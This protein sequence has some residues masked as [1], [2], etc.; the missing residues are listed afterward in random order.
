MRERILE[1]IKKENKKLNPIDIMNKI[2][3]NSS[4]EDLRSLIHELDLMCRDGI[5]RCSS[6][7]TYVLNDLLSGELDVHEKGNAH[8][9]V[10][11]GDD[12]FI[13]RDK[14][15]GAKNKDTVLVEVTNKEKGEGK[16]VKILSR[17]IGNNVAEV[18][19]V[20]GELIVVPLKNEND[21]IIEFENNDL[22]LVEGQY[23]HIEY[24]R[25]LG[26]GKILAR[27]D[28]V[29]GHKN[30]LLNEG[31]E[32]T[33][34][35]GEIAK[36][37]CE[38]GLNLLF[39]NEVLE[40]ASKM[41]KELS[42][43]MI[44]SG[45]ENGRE[46]FRNEIIFTIDGKDTKDIDDAIS[47]KMLPNGNY[48]LG[49][50]IADVSYYVK[51]GSSI[52]K[53]AEKRGNSNYLGNKVL[54]M[55]PVE[56][57]NGI[58]SLNPNVDRFTTSCVMEIDASGKV[59]NRRVVKGIINSK[60]KMNYDAVQDLIDN[61]D[62]EDTKDYT[63]LSYTAIKG[64]T[65]D[66]IA[67]ANCIT[68][69]ELKKYN[70]SINGD[71]IGKEIN[72]PCK[73]VIKNAYILS[74]LIS[75]YKHTRGEII[76]DGDEAKIYQDENDEPYEVSA[77]DQR[78]AERIIEDFMV[79]ANEQVAEFLTECNL[80]TYRIHAQPLTKKMEDYLKYLELCGIHYN[81][82][83]NTEN[84][85][86]RECQQLLEYLREKE[87]SMYKVLNKKLLR[88]MQK[89]EY[90][91]ENIGH[92][93]IASPCY[94][95]FTSPIRR[96]DDLL[97]H[98][99]LGY[100]LE[101]ERMDERFIKSWTAYLNTLCAYISECERNSEKCEY[102]VDDMLKARFME[103]HIGEEFDV[104]V[105]NIM[106]GAFFVQTD[107]YIDGRVDTIIKNEK[108][109][110]IAGYYNYDDKLM[111]YTRNGRVD[112]RSG[113]RVRVKCVNSDYLSREIDFALVR[114]L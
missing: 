41:P 73:N 55:L 98:T 18:M 99:S 108:E 80:A 9:I 78:P 61:K 2:K 32:P 65:L 100:I 48:E 95:H 21:Y 13:P 49:V 14:I 17:S 103:S 59:V 67:F 19:N 92:F 56:L 63:T 20:D 68:V 51:P 42:S 27:V 54:P 83:F 47:I 53:E 90:S 16:V 70:P 72:V 5:L 112:L 38:F 77:R 45:L 28:K 104:T 36:I 1:I 25:D 64:D 11:D 114:K 84:V 111:A 3:K 52:W 91:T 37:A 94:T 82:R 76:F 12:I 62:T 33:T 22:N 24:L 8:L 105:D 6:G 60:K 4:V 35:S 43:E 44:N 79:C 10:K 66:S 26:K 87:E 31:Q 46:D 34:I 109:S 58:C 30:A 23:V 69:D 88:S 101:E 89:A 15:K 110:S 113:D 50:H 74:K 81:G 71:I 57:S 86:S 106:Q 102:A 40:E 29:L 85:S 93:G 107:N 96:M 7:N 39:P 97:N 75:N